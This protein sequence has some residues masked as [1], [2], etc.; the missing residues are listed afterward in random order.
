MSSRRATNGR[1]LL[2]RT[3]HKYII[4][5]R[6]TTEVG[7]PALIHDRSAVRAEHHAGEHSVFSRFC[8]MTAR[9]PCR[10]RGVRD[11]LYPDRVSAVS[12][13]RRDNGA[14]QNVGKICFPRRKENSA[15]SGRKACPLRC[16]VFAYLVMSAVHFLQRQRKVTICA[17]VQSASGLNVVLVV[18]LVI[19]SLTAHSTASA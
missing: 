2:T 7:G 3:R 10:S 5:K 18:P 4:R 6:H 11:C 15:V 8:R 1:P 9:P 17:L 16:F 12:L 14:A 19:F 13:P